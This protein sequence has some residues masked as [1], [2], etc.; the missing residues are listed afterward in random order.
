M[1]RHALSLVVIIVF[2][3]SPT[4]H[5]GYQVV[6]NQQVAQAVPPTVHLQADAQLQSQCTTCTFTTYRLVRQLNC[7]A[8]IAVTDLAGKPT[9]KM[10]PRVTEQ[11]AVELLWSTVNSTVA[12]IDLGVG[13]VTLGSG[14]RIITPQESTTYNMTVINE[15]G[16]VGSCSARIEVNNIGH[17][18]L[19]ETQIGDV[20]VP[21]ADIVLND[22]NSAINSITVDSEAQYQPYIE[23]WYM[24]W[25]HSI[26]SWIVFMII[27]IGSVLYYVIK[28][29]VRKS[30]Q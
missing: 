29:F 30:N 25:L 5:A 13:H 6:P 7:G 14:K 18:E 17:G 10:V 28:W 26:W 20:P 24:V 23:P 9:C 11:G 15:D 3:L 22:D 12:F 8:V 1:F 27:V 21:T 4:V 2:L 19:Y 16:V